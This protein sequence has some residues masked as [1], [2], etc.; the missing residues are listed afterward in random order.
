V[1]IGS[2][3]T[4][5]SRDFVASYKSPCKGKILMKNEDDPNHPIITDNEIQDDDGKNLKVFK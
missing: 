2:I 4:E 1:I 3:Y 5:E